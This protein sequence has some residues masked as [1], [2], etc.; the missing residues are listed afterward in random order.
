MGTKQIV[1]LDKVV[2][3]LCQDYGRRAELISSHN[4][5]RR[6]DIECRY[7]NFKIFDAVG[8]ISGV[9]KHIPIYIEEIGS[10]IGY[11][12]SRLS[13]LSDRMMASSPI[14]SACARSSAPPSPST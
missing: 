14:P 6:V 8:E 5:S 1:T 13:F 4:A 10:S 3:A 2:I 11:A 9:E 12:Q 7:M